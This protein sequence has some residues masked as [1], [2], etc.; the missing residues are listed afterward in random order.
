M[1]PN[2]ILSPPANP[3][4]SATAIIWDSTADTGTGTTL[5]RRRAFPT[6]KRIRITAFIDQAA[7]FKV[8]GI[9]AGSS[10]WRTT[11]GGGSG[12][13]ITASTYFERDVLMQGEDVKVYITTGTAP[14]T[15]EIT[16]RL[17]HESQTLGQ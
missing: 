15:W 7:T 1:H 9:A 2:T 6:V 3:G 12:E 16:A 11:N 17:I 5:T 14:T 4:G 13:S 10:T 8:D